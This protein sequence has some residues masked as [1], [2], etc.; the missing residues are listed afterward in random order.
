MAWGA[1]VENSC[2]LTTGAVTAMRPALAKIR[3]D[4]VISD[5]I[6]RKGSMSE[7]L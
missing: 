5:E 6:E 2:A 4:V 3:D 7:A 1:V